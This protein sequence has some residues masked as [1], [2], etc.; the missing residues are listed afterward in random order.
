MAITKSFDNTTEEILKPS[1]IAKKID[2]F[3]EI[4][5]VTFNEKML[6]IMR[7]NNPS[8]TI[9]TVNAGYQH[10][11][12]KTEYKGKTIAFYMTSIG[13]PVTVG[14]LEE[15]LIKGGKKILLF[16]SCDSLDNNISDGH[17][18]VP[19][20]AYRDEGTSYHYVS[21][22]NGDFINVKTANKTFEILKEL[23]IP[24]IYGKTW[25]TDAIYRETRRNKE[26]RKKDG[27]ITVEMECAS[28]MALAQYRKA[29]IFQFLYTADNLD[30]S[31]WESR[32]LGNLPEDIRE[33]YV[34]IAF[35][36]AIRL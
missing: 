36:V 15:I 30:C 3:P 25:T 19:T 17:I 32:F 8:E 11:I 7:N 31:Q 14:L 1:N 12:Y 21:A 33:R 24:V 20:H 6:N 27:C 13:A 22:N 9:D 18:V 35:E 4:V 16:G 29:N 10:K 23:N 26:Q 5:I 28:V 2:G 34:K